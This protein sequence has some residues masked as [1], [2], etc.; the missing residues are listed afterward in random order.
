MLTRSGQ[1]ACLPVNRSTRQHPWF[2]FCLFSGTFNLRPTAN[3]T[4]HHSS[5]C[6]CYNCRDIEFPQEIV[7]MAHHVGLHFKLKRTFYTSTWEKVNG[8]RHVL[9]L[10]R[11]NDGKHGQ[12]LMQMDKNQNLHLYS[13]IGCRLVAHR[14]KQCGVRI[15]VTGRTDSAK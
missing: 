13:N 12:I 10:S 14:R 9:C 11:L 6:F 2:F 1:K 15:S 8:L 4:T 3:C 5:V 7:L